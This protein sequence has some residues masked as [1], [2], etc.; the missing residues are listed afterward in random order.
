[1]IYQIESPYAV[2]HL[3][4]CDDYGVLIMSTEFQVLMCNIGA[5]EQTNALKMVPRV[6]IQFAMHVAGFQAN[7][8]Y[9]ASASHDG[10][11]SIVDFGY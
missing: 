8:R 7:E 9:L 6:V 4:Y 10:S 5:A 3:Q 2:E 1:M 11:V